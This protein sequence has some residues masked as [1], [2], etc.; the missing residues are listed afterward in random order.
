MNGPL[1]R[2]TDV[3]D[4][5]NVVIFV[6][7]AHRFDFLPD[8]VK[9]LGLTAKAIAPSTF[10]ASALPSLT[11]GQYPDTHKVWMF[12]DQLA[13]RPPLL[14]PTDQEI[15]VGFDAETV[16]TK[17]EQSEK[18]P[19]QIHHLDTESKLRELE[20]PFVHVVHDVGPHAP[21]GFENGVFESTKEFFREYENRRP[22]LIDL[23][24]QDC[25]NSVDRFMNVYNQLVERDLLD[26][27]LVAFT[28]DHGQ[29]LGERENGGRF[30]HGHPMSPEN[31]EIPVVFMGA[32]LPRGETYDTLLS[33]T[34]IAPT[35]LSA[36][37]GTV[38]EDVDGTDIWRDTPTVERRVRSDVWQNLEVTVGDHS[39]EISVYAACGLWN[40]SGGYVFHQKS[41]LQR[42]GALFF[43]D[44]CRGYSP[45]WR[46]NLSPR[47]LS[48]FTR[49]AL[50]NR[51][52][53]GR[54]DFSDSLAFS[55]VPKDF[56]KGTH[57]FSDNALSDAQVTQLRDLGYLQ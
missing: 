40:D 44:L 25:H 20:P 4:V 38:P 39:A 41:R 26:E 14:D 45:A 47:K 16:W 50:S 55:E 2:L 54:P 17:L 15:D 22:Q 30:G 48:T 56:E 11:T 24:R 6:S 51:L 53:Y 10:T 12:D 8:E 29:C 52:K 57:D 7:D 49:L 9:R 31:V 37:R 36:Q 35:A 32:G 42:L 3:D 23:Y 43:D 28:S 18:P 46:G 21:Y 1:S 13:A 19:L 33:G 5:E 27:T 34:D